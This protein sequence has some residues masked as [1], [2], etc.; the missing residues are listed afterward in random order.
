MPVQRLF[1]GA[2]ATQLF[3]HVNWEIQVLCEPLD[4]PAR[5][6]NP[7]FGTFAPAEKPKRGQTPI[8][9]RCGNELPKVKSNRGCK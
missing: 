9:D 7:H 3:A 1:S 6:I 4:Y 8:L 2:W 5:D